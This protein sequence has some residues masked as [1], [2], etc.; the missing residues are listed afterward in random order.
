MMITNTK[1]KNLISV[2]SK[3]F[4]SLKNKYINDEG[5]LIKK[6]FLKP[7]KISNGAVYISKINVFLKNKNLYDPD[8]LTFVMDSKSSIDIDTIDDIN[9]AISLAD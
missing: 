7:I 1:A 9:K 6:P 8:C 4:N 2:E 5:F 3:I